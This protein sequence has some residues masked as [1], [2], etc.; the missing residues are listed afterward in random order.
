MESPTKLYEYFRQALNDYASSKGYGV[1]RNIA[2]QAGITEAFVSQII[3]GTNK[4]SARTQASIARACGFPALEDMLQAGKSSWNKTAE[5]EAEH[6]LII[7]V[8]SQSEKAILS[9]SIEDYRGIPLYGSGRLA[10]GANGMAFDPYEPPVS[11]VVI[12]NPEIQGSAR[13]NLSALKVGGDSMAPTIPQGA[14][15]VVDLSDREQVD[16]RIF[17][18][19]VPDGGIDM[20]AVKRVRR[21]EKGKG[22]VLISDN[23]GYPPDISLLDWHRLCVGRVVW[24]SK[25]VRQ[26]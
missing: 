3:A 23:A 9:G 5:P 12:Y 10:A 13:H 18:V 16:G 21:W 6:H 22:F 1:Q 2:M 17:V 19:N 8:Q 15:V 20:A 11:M 24:M 7:Q 25:N 4:A 26:A 14:V